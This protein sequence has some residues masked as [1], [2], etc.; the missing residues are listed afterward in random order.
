MLECFDS[1]PAHS[2]VL[3]HACCHNPT[4]LD[5]SP[6]QWDTLIG[7]FAERKLIPFLDAAYLGMGDGLEADSHAIRALARAG[8]TGLV[9]N[10]FSKVFSLYGERVGVVVDSLPGR[11]DC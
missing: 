9:S 7:L 3:L 4:G 5:L 8:I 2:I 11:R 10:S 6:G 1:L